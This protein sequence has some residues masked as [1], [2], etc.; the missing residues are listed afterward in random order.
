VACS[1]TTEKI[2]AQ[3]SDAKFQEHENF[4]SPLS[5]RAKLHIVRREQGVRSLGQFQ[6]RI[7]LYHILM[8]AIEPT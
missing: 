4:I 8:R 1:K 3:L 7:L 2:A 5:S 6:G